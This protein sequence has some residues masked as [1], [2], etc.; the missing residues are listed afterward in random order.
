VVGVAAPA[1]AVSPEPPVTVTP[2]GLACKHPGEGQND[3]TYRF[4]FC[5]E[6]NTALVG[7]TVNLVTMTIDGG[8]EVETKVAHPTS[9]TVVAGTQTCIFVDAVNFHDSANGI[10]TL[11]FSYKLASAPGTTITDSVSTAFNDLPPC[12]TGA[13]NFSSPKDW[14]HDPFGPPTPANCVG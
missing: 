13:D 8:G 6:T 4:T 10:A 3:K 11:T 7:N 9:V 1:F 12:G 2:C 14:P 5:F